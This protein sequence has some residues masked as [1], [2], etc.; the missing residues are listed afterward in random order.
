MR[1]TV[2]MT[3]S[4]IR[5][6]VSSRK[7]SV[8]SAL[9]VKK[10][11]APSSKAHARLFSAGSTTTTRSAPEA[12]QASTDAAPMPPSPITTAV[13]PGRT[14]ATL[15]TAPHPVDTPQPSREARS[16]GIFFLHL[17]QGVLMDCD[18]GSKAADVAQRRHFLVSSRTNPPFVVGDR[19]SADSPICLIADRAVS[20]EARTAPSA[21]RDRRQHNVVAHGKGGDR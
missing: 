11:V 13:S 18:V 8:A 3:L 17:H 4:A 1:P 16:R 9:E 6:Q 10:W 19:F 14:W 12:T 5:P 15:T 7:A 20:E 2:I 21:P